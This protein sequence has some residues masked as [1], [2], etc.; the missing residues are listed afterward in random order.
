MK[1]FKFALPLTVCRFVP[2]NQGT[3]KFRIVAPSASDGVEYYSK[4][5]NDDDMQS[6]RKAR[7]SV[8]ANQGTANFRIGSPF[9]SDG[10]VTYSERANG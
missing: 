8:T 3:V 10:V 5:K 9:A 2:P 7:T 1:I 6:S 4:R